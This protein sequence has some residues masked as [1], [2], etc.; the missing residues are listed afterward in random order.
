MKMPFHSYGPAALCRMDSSLLRDVSEPCKQFRIVVMACMTVII[1]TALYGFAFGYWRSPVQGLYSAVKMP[2]LFL[3]VILTTTAINTI[4]AQI[5]GAG[6]SL[7]QVTMIVLLAMAVASAIL[8]CFS[9][10]ALFLVINLPSPD[11]SIL[12]L[13]FSDPLVARSAATYWLLLLGHV[14]VIGAA[15]IAGNIRLYRLLRGLTPKKMALGLLLTWIVVIGFVGCQLSWLFSPFLCKP[16]QLPHIFPKEYFQEN[17]YERVLRA[18][19][20]VLH[21]P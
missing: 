16:T 4:L 13:P 7:R 18:I 12:G 5:M 8:G 9:P 21:G 10:V 2:L 6:L 11:P 1:G 3:S 20:A 17:F 19:V 14:A 15:G